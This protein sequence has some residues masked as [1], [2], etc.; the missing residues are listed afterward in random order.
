[1]KKRYLFLII[2]F[3]AIILTGCGIKEKNNRSIVNKTNNLVNIQF[4]TPD[5]W[6]VNEDKDN[7]QIFF[8]P[9]ENDSNILLLVQYYETKIKNINEEDYNIFIDSFL[10]GFTRAE[11]MSMPRVNSKE[12]AKDGDFYECYADIKADYYDAYRELLIYNTFDNKT[13]VSYTFG[14]T[15]PNNVSEEDKAIFNEITNSIALR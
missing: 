10:D 4:K 8:Y 6:I 3:F 9:S 12:I 1:M 15:S 13:G 11:G 7:N 14:F 2:C 5:F